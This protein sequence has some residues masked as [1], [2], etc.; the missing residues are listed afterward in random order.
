MLVKL[1]LTKFKKHEDLTVNFVS[2]LNVIRGLNEAGK[3]SIYH[4]I[5]YALYGSKIGRASCRERV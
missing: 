5:S 4:A 2:G 3:S 1:V